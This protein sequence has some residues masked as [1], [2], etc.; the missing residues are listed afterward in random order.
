MY[1]YNSWELIRNLS[2]PAASHIVSLAL[3]HLLKFFFTLKSIPIVAIYRF[4]TKSI[5]CEFQQQAGLVRLTLANNE[6][7][8]GDQRLS[9]I[10]SSLTPAS[11]LSSALQGEGIP[12][13]CCFLLKLKLVLRNLPTFL[14]F[15][16]LYVCQLKWKGQKKKKEWDTFTISSVHGHFTFDAKAWIS[17]RASCL[18]FV[19]VCLSFFSFLFSSFLSLFFLSFDSIYLCNLDCLQIYGL[20][21]PLASVSQV[22][23]MQCI[24]THMASLFYFTDKNVYSYTAFYFEVYTI[25]E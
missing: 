23:G 7:L 25:V 10:L 2:W 12:C 3:F 4:W 20:Y 22:L 1:H 21:G 9:C 16:T 14:Y 17:F 11:L 13:L 15:K 18:I 6:A 8:Q 24:W 5:M 19:V